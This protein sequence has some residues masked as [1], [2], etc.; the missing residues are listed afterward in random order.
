MGKSNRILEIVGE[1]ER[2]RRVG[3]VSGREEGCGSPEK[4]GHV[5]STQWRRKFNEI[6]RVEQEPKAGGSL[7]E[8]TTR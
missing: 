3:H 2:R 5:S 7:P 6:H 8:S 1:R 4:E